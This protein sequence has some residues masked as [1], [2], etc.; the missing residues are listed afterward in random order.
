MNGGLIQIVKRDVSRSSSV[1]ATDELVLV[2]DR[3]MVEGDFLTGGFAV[4]IDGI[5]LQGAVRDTIFIPGNGSA[6]IQF[7]A[8][9]PGIWAFHCHV[10]YHLATGMFT[11]VLYEGFD[12]KEWKPEMTPT[13]L[14]NSG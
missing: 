1:G 6:K 11:V 13:E 3:P 2:F 14:E 5:P 8:N 12:P 9:N 10:L 4:E 7:D